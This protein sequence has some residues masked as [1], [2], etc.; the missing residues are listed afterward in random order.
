MTHDTNCIPTAYVWSTQQSFESSC[1]FVW[2]H[3]HSYSHP[4]Y[5]QNLASIATKPGFQTRMFPNS[6][7]TAH[8]REIRQMRLESGCAWERAPYPKTLFR[9][10]NASQN[11][12]TALRPRR[13]ATRVV[14]CCLASGP[15]HVRLCCFRCLSKLDLNL[16]EVSVSHHHVLV[17]SDW[18]QIRRLEFQQK[19]LFMNNC[20]ICKP[21]LCTLKTT[22]TCFPH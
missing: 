8:M 19:A 3:C 12:I 20:C 18:C 22:T 6:S 9:R 1:Q 14:I 10:A 21:R 2:C 17:L 4:R 5:S 7:M 16:E 11:S 13:N 15:R